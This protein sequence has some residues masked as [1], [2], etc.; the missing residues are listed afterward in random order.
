MGDSFETKVIVTLAEESDALDW[1]A[2]VES[3]TEA[4]IYHRYSWK[5][6]I[7]ANTGHQGLFFIARDA[8]GRVCGVLPIIYMQSRLF[9]NF[10]ISIPFF[11]YGG[12]LAN[13]INIEESLIAEASRYFSNTSA[14]Y[15]EYRE[16]KERP[17][18]PVK[19]DKVT[20]ML[21]LPSDADAMLNGFKAKLR[22]QIKRPIRENVTVEFGGKEFLDDF[23]H[24]FTVNMRDLGTPPYAKAFFASIL[25]SFPDNAFLAIARKDGVAVG[26]AFLIG[27]KGILEIP[28]ASTIRKYNSIGVNML[29]YWEVIRL[30][31]K[32]GYQSFD[33]GRC[34]RGAGT[35]KFKKQ[36]GSEEVPLYWHYSLLKME[37]LPQINPNNPK[38]QLFIRMWQKLPLPITRIVGPHLVKNIPG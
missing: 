12:P 20:M 35:Y 30:A 37:E 17:G 31:I 18:Y 24:V 2:Y 6:L 32:Q 8:T 28:W 22:S 15:L 29:M 11:N 19:S 25:T 5:S 26:A 14:Q 33:F 3:R 7:E 27:F 16:T 38:Y 21:S 36:W 23:Y 4:K 9:G 34:T 10:G 1:D 13:N